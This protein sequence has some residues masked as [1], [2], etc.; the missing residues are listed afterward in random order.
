MAVKTPTLTVTGATGRGWL[1]PSP[2]HKDV[3]LDLPCRPCNKNS[4][5]RKDHA[6]LENLLP[7]VV[8]RRL[9]DMLGA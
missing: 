6:C 2:D 5:A 9:L 4:C 3:F 1:Y 7:E 8:T